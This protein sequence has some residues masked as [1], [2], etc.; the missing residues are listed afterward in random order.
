MT[1]FLSLFV[2]WAIIGQLESQPDRIARLP[3]AEQRALLLRFA[4]RFEE[5]AEAP[6]PVEGEA[7]ELRELVQRAAALF[8]D[9]PR[10]H[11][12]LGVTH[13]RRGRRAEAAAAWKAALAAPSR[14]HDPGARLIRALC[15]YRLGT[16]ELV[17]G[18]V[19]RAVQHANATIDETPDQV[20]GYEL[21]IDASLRAGNVRRV[22][23]TL[24]SAA[25][26]Y[27][28]QTH[29]LQSLYLDLLAQTGD[30]DGLRTRI[31]ALE[32]SASRFDDVQHYRGRLAELDR[33]DRAAFVHHF[34]AMQS[35]AED[36]P[37]TIRSRQYV[38]HKLQD[39][40]TAGASPADRLLRAYLWHD[41]P[42]T[43]QKSLELLAAYQ[44]AGS[45]ETLLLDHLR[46]RAR[47]VLGEVDRARIIW[48]Q[49]V[50]RWPEYVP[51]LCFLGELAEA[52]GD[53][54]KADALF[55]RARQLRQANWKVR[56]IDRLGARFAVA[57]NG[58]KVRTLKSAAPLA[59]LGVEPE[60]VLLQ[61]DDQVLADL[62]AVERIAAVRALEVADLVF[63]TADGTVLRRQL[64]PDLRK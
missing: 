40:R 34:L 43:A 5:L 55:D 23:E 3:A 56:Q 13:Q 38:S 42:E 16:H 14:L 63:Q 37:A 64:G 44:T 32:A 29:A 19:D 41:R 15:H 36:R 35:G 10:I 61:I 9:E 57:A 62:P 31:V 33:N 60:C 21:L 17:V 51:A 54:T 6:L 25:E 50:A 12:W 22:V 27:G 49:V 52:D 7:D 2:S 39:V 53:F 4:S 20:A 24:R 48:E 1:R 11:Y 45:E 18:N 59:R 28:S 46:A 8:P 47:T 58:V 30:W 26:R